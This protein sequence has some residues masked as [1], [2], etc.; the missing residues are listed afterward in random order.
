MNFNH[1][2]PNNFSMKKIIDVKEIN[3]SA[4]AYHLPKR[5]IS[6]SSENPDAKLFDDIKFLNEHCSNT[7]IN[8]LK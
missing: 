1:W 6:I 3:N 4:I 5:Y 2:H 7:T 8:I